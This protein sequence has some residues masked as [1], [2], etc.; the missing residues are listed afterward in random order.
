MKLK[1]YFEQAEGSGVLATADAHGK[2]NVAIYARPHFL[3]EHDGSTSSFM[4][5]ALTAIFPTRCETSWAR[6]RW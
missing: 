1:E 4:P 2:V 6:R 3:D 5:F